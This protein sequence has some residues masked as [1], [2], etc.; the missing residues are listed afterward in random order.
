MHTIKLLKVVAETTEKP[1]MSDS[2]PKFTER[3][4]LH[5]TDPSLPP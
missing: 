1:A 4:N 5:S 3:V 2:C